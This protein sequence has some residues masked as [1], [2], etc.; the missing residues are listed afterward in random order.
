[1]PVADLREAAWCDAK[2]AKSLLALTINPQGAIQDALEC[3]KHALAGFCPLQPL[4]DR[5]DVFEAALYIG[6]VFSDAEAVARCHGLHKRFRAEF[7][8]MSA[9]LSELVDMEAY[10]P[11]ENLESLRD[12]LN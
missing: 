3:L 6:F 8:E 4:M 12:L 7:A 11:R 1:M 2:R 5:D 10:V 9:S